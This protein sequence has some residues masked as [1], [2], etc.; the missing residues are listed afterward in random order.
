VPGALLNRGTL[1]AATFQATEAD[2]DQDGTQRGEDVKVTPCTGAPDSLT[3]CCGES[4]QCCADGST[5]AQHTIAA[6]FGDPIPTATSSL[7]SSSATSSIESSIAS[8]MVSAS[9]SSIAVATGDSGLSAGAKAGIGVGAALGAIALGV[10]GIFIAKALRWRKKARD[11][12]TSYVASE[13]YPSKDIYRHE[14]SQPA[15]L[16]CAESQL[17]EMPGSGGVSELDQV[18][19]GGIAGRHAIKP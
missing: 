15:Q 16:A 3:W 8:S 19:H 5:I 18:P 2:D 6:R 10:L 11:A 4:N 13:E 1:G 12:N 14:G 9:P 7:V 17:Y